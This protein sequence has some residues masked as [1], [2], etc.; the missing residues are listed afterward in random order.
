MTV[1]SSTEF[2]INQNRYFD[3]AMKEHVF[4][5]RGNNMFHLLCTNIDDMTVK[6]RVWY[7]PDADFYRSVTKDELLKGINEDIDNFFAN[8]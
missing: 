5:Q 8:K 6:E 1:V 7:E 4:V 2:A 3:M